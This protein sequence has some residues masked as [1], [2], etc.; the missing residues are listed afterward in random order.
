MHITLSSGELP[1]TDQFFWKSCE[2]IT[3]NMD[4]YPLKILRNLILPPNDIYLGYGIK[5]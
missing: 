5:V 3:D 2:F 1:D 4:S